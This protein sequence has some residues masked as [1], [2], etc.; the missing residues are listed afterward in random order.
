MRKFLIVAMVVFTAEQL[1]SQ[2]R[3][4]T[5]IDDFY[6]DFSVPDL[7][8]LSLL[9]IKN[10]EIVRPGNMKEF[11]AAL[12]N[13]VDSDGSL[14]SALALEWSFMRTFKK[15]S[16]INWNKPF[17]G[18]NIALTLATTEQDSLGTRIG[19]GVKFSPIDKSDPFANPDFYKKIA[20]LSNAF[21][22]RESVKK[23][24]GFD[25]LVP[26]I[27]NFPDNPNM[28]T[29]QRTVYKVVID[30]LDTREKAMTDIRKKIDQG[31][32]TNLD[33]TFHANMQKAFEDN[34]IPSTAISPEQ[35]SEIIATY[36][37][38][39]Q[40]TY[41][42]EFIEYKEFITK[43]IKK[44]KEEFKK[45]HWNALAWQTSVGWV[46]HSLSSTYNDLTSERFSAFTGVSI[47][48]RN[49]DKKKLKGQLIAQL[50]YSLDVSGDSIDFNEFSAGIKHLYGN[51]DNRLS[52]EVLYSS[53]ETEL[54]EIKQIQPV[55]YLRYMLGVELKLFDGTWL[56]L[57]FGGQK[58]F[59]GQNEK[60]TIL[61]DFGFKHAIR[62]KR[63]YDN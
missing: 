3:D 44:Q 45:K 63:R 39:I 20:S 46:A 4:T 61:S 35:R 24:E 53:A 60:N 21:Y 30:V 36:V 25:F 41:A 55:K 52:V 51:S 32:I 8:A 7:S 13:F 42:D 29:L 15:N 5:N 56:E 16:P 54:L 2:Q 43:I 33:S 62:N 11:A 18:R 50:K 57:A 10:D 19:F 14:K 28:T 47:P 37:A 59:E 38:L 34:N 27:L 9:G 48:T 1:F 6:I 26:K 49:D 17:Q 23:R 12:A 31:T 40:E 22:S 58:F